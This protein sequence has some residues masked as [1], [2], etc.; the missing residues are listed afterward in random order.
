MPPLVAAYST[1][2]S[3]SYPVNLFSLRSL[4]A[5]EL[6]KLFSEENSE[7]FPPRILLLF[8]LLLHDASLKSHYLNNCIQRNY[9]V[10]NQY[11]QSS[12]N[13][14]A[15]VRTSYIWHLSSLLIHSERT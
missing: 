11:A 15:P 13:Y 8:I 7:P 6:L 5:N 4:K 12:E 9:Q 2:F 14:D 1:A 10:N 3:L